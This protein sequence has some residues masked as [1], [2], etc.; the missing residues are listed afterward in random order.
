LVAYLYGEAAPE[1]AKAFRRHLNACAVCREE[2]AAF[3]AVREAVGVWRA[4]VLS[5]APALD[6][7]E[8]L[9]PAP[10]S[11]RAP[12]RKRSAAVA[13]RE[14]FA[15]SPL[16][17]QAGASA[18]VV[19]VCALAALTLARAEVRWDSNGLAFRTGV[20]GGAVTEPVQVPLKSGYTEEQFDAAV[21]EGV[22]RRLAD[23]RA[24]LEG[25]YARRVSFLEAELKQQKAAARQATATARQ[26]SPR[27]ATPGGAQGTQLA[28]ENED[29]FSAREERGVPRLT[30]LLGAVNNPR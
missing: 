2:L 9:A 18:A 16:W 8:E 14:F 20:K 3:G 22:E 27:R 25:E 21:K 29:Y 19:V 7:G 6:I 13:L 28:R 17:L 1:E 4:E 23:E 26:Q 5:T 24:E 12:G 11:R 15:L 30:D 10:G